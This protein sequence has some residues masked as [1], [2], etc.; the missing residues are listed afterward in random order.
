MFSL[1]KQWLSRQ[2]ICAL[3][4]S[5]AG[6]FTGFVFGLAHAASPMFDPTV[7]QA[8]IVGMALGLLA[9]V[10][11]LFFIGV[12]ADYGVWQIFWQT[13]V[14]SELTSIITVLVI[15]AVHAK[16]AGMLIGW[17]IGFLVGRALCAAC[18]AVFLRRAKS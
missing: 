11:I 9:W 10:G 18:K 2:G 3:C 15:R 7:K 4:G 5:I 1:L 6:S 13:F 8:V 17:V 12:L 16:S 14:N